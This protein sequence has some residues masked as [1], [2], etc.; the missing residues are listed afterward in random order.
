VAYAAL[1]VVLLAS[2]LLLL[3]GS[4]A[5]WWPAG[6]FALIPDLAVLYGIAPG[7]AHGQLNPRA[8]P[9]HNALH[10]FWGPLGLIIVVVAAALPRAWLAAALAWALHVAFDR[11]IGLRLRSPDGFQRGNHT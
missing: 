6:A 10:R 3:I 1:A 11:V 7:L 4:T 2:I 9:L 5:D 8:V